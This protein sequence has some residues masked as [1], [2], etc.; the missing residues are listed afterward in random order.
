[1][2]VLIIKLLRIKQV[3]PTPPTG[4]MY[5]LIGARLWR[6]GDDI[7]LLYWNLHRF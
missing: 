6:R 2:T 3:A 7:C 1:M 5:L 4:E